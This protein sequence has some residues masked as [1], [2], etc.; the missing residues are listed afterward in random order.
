MQQIVE[1]G[2][3]RERVEI[4]DSPYHGHIGRMRRACGENVTID[5]GTLALLMQRAAVARGQ[6][7]DELRIVRGRVFLPA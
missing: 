4:V 1:I 3:L 2:S 6:T 5:E 7:G